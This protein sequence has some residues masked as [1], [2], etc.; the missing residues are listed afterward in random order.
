TDIRRAIDYFK[1]H[2]ISAPL[3]EHEAGGHN[4]TG[5]ARTPHAA[6]AHADGEPSSSPLPV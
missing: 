2:P 5:R 1:H 3:T 6:V 4:H